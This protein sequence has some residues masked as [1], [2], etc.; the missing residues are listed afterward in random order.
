LRRRSR[1][2]LVEATN[3]PEI[4]LPVRPGE[5]ACC[6]F[7]RPEDRERLTIAFVRAGL[8]RGHKVIYLHDRVDPDGFVERLLTADARV[9]PALASGQLELRPARPAYL[10]DGGFDPDR[11]ATTLRVEH[12]RARAAGFAG[13]SITGDVSV[14]CGEPGD[15]AL[16]HYEEEF[17]GEPFDASRLILCHYPNDRL[18]PAALSEVVGHHDVDVSPELA[19]IGRE[20]ALSAARVRATQALRLAG[21]LDFDGAPAVDDVLAA[22]F[23]GPLR[24]DLADLTYA[25]IAGM[26]ALRGRTGQTVAIDGASD[27]VR[28]LAELLAWDTDPDVELPSVQPAA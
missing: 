5:H 20:G 11:L 21:E 23:H 1:V 25:D 28:R 24:L 26:R 17:D 2:L 12:Q 22:H 6:R 15:D 13:I 19:P 14:V 18:P 10:P 16:T 3:T 4:A 9:A 7:A 8:G 27:A